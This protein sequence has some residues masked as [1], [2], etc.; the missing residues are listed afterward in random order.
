MLSDILQITP[1]GV[2]KAE[3]SSLIC[4]PGGF[5]GLQLWQKAWVAAGVWLWLAMLQVWVEYAAATCTTPLFIQHGFVCFLNSLGLKLAPHATREQSR[6]HLHVVCG[7][8]SAI[9]CMFAL[10]W[11][12]LKSLKHWTL[13]HRNYTSFFYCRLYM[14]STY[15]SQQCGASIVTCHNCTSIHFSM[16]SL[17]TSSSSKSSDCS[18]ETNC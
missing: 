14:S 8:C 10:V 1:C 5:P 17:G 2:D 3:G 7:V 16:K 13:S 6:E 15:L 12:Q 9:Y 18:Q 11:K 4:G